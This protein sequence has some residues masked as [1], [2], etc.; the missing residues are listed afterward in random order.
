MFLP[1]LSA[2]QKISGD[3]TEVAISLK[4]IK[5]DRSK[6]RAKFNLHNT[7]KITQYAT[8]NESLIGDDQ[9]REVAKQ[10]EIAYHFHSHTKSPIHRSDRGI[11]SARPFDL[12]QRMVAEGRG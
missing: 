8:G 3:A 9:D 2:Y 6:L 4:T 5:N 12:S 10:P 7:A 11:Y 1:L